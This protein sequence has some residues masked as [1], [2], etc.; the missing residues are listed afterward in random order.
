[1]PPEA[2]GRRW[3]ARAFGL[4]IDASF[5]APGLPEAVGGPPGRPVRADLVE[6]A[7]IDGSWPA[8]GCERV[9]E[10]MYEEREPVRTID[11]HPEAGYRLYA[12][13]FG[14]ARLSPS[15]DAVACSPPDDEPWSWQRFLVGRILPWAAALR[16][17]EPFHASAVAADGGVLAFVAPT[18]GG[19]TSLAVQL[20]ARGARFFTDDV[21]ALDEHGGTLRAHPGAAIA[22]VRDAARAA[23]APD[24]WTALGSELGH[25][26]KTYMEIPREHSPAPLR[27]VYYLR[28]RPEPSI[29]PIE[30]P[31]PRLLLT[32]TF[33]FGV[34]TPERLAT[35]LDVCARIARTVPIFT[36]GI[37]ESAGSAAAAAAVEE[38]ARAAVPAG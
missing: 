12:R 37:S 27:A 6:P 23:I 13:G 36:L 20:V 1:M 32:S 2:D 5:P 21:L 25:S 8:E 24:T 30:R 28:P 18:G 4:E 22:A 38:H 7:E 26:G 10:E 16:G 31:G 9:L 15:G 35:Q 19:K 3:T 14:L 29:E 17:L 11:S 34:R 33:V